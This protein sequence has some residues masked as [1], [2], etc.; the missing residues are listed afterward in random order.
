MNS[1]LK[2]NVAIELPELLSIVA[3]TSTLPPSA[4]RLTIVKR[5][6]D[7]GSVDVTATIDNS[8]GNSIATLTFSGEFTET[9]GSLV[10]GNYQLTVFGDQIQ[11]ASGQSFDADGDGIAGGNSV[12]GDSEADEFFRL[13]GDSNGDRLVNV[14]DLLS[15]RQAWLTNEDDP[16]FDSAFDSNADG[17]ISVFDLL[18]FRQNWLATSEF[19]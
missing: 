16:D 7:G 8:S 12:F 5:G 11:T 2:V 4:P 15:F 14:F 6:A 3:V 17:N 19:V 1:P 9:T 13:F 18:R 10:D